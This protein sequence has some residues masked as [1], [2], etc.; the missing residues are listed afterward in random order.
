MCWGGFSCCVLISGLGSKF[1][2][3][4]V[5]RTKRDQSTCSMLFYFCPA[6]FCSCVKLNF[7]CVEYCFWVLD[8]CKPGDK[9]DLKTVE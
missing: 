9:I 2:C 7:G 3:L 6:T 1:W 8:V 5:M 4:S